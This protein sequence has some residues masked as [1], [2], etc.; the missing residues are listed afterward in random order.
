MIFAVLVLFVAFWCFFPEFAICLS[1][2]AQVNNGLFASAV[3][4]PSVGK[5]TFFVL[6]E[7]ADEF[8]VFGSKASSRPRSPLLSL[9]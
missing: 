6:S 5:A 7:G 1:I 4:H 3:A 8:G 2:P 9:V